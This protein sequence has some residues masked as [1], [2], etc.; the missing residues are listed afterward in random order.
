[1]IRRFYLVNEKE[2]TFTLFG[3]G[4]NKT[5]V[6]SLDNLG[7]E[8]DI[9]YH[10]FDARFVEINR[11]IPQKTISMTLIFYEGYAGFTKW[12]EFVTKS[13]TLRLFYEIGDIKYCYVN[14]KSSSKTELESGVLKSEIQVECLSLW[15]VNKS[16][17]INVVKT[18][19]G[20]TYTYAYPYTYAVSYNGKTTVQNDSSR[21]VPLK[22][23]L[24]GNCLNP[25]VI[26][27]QNNEVVCALRILTDERENPKLIINADPTDQ[28]IKKILNG[29]ETD[30]YNKQDFSYENFLYLPPGKCEIFFDPGVREPATCLIE[31]KEEYIAH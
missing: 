16:S 7:F 25:R 24:N 31:F 6:E 11:T 27:Y 4:R 20:K 21:N 19:E 1:M 28:Y 13:K 17:T 10:E 18:D 29:N 15:L 8:F 14:I 23:T 5:D 2:N 12:R 26:V 22:I 30:I 9:E 3:Y